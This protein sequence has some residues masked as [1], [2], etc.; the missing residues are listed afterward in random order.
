MLTDPTHLCISQQPPIKKKNTEETS[1]VVCLN[2]GL[3]S[4]NLQM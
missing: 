3:Q 1:S 2:I 4:L